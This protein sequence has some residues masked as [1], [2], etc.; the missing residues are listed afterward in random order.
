M[1]R[2]VHIARKICLCFG[3]IMFTIFLNHLSCKNVNVFYL[4]ERRKKK[5]KPIYEKK[6]CQC[7]GKTYSCKKKM[8]VEKGYVS[9]F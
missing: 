6:I 3:K 9:I 4:N 8:C 1:K 2:N 5:R 7:I